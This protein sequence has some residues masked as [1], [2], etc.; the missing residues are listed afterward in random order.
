MLAINFVTRDYE[1]MLQVRA[2][3]VFLAS[4]LVYVCF[5]AQFSRTPALKTP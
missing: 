3:P 1:R 5:R 4:C 2:A